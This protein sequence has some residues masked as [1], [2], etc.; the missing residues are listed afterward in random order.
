VNGWLLGLAT[1]QNPSDILKM[2]LDFGLDP[3]AR[4]RVEPE[5]EYE[6]SFTWGMPPL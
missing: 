3:D 4:T 5:G 6:I 1:K 2:L